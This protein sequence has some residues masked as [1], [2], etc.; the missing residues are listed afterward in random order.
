MRLCPLNLFQ[1]PRRNLGARKLVLYATK[2]AQ[3][4]VCLAGG[5]QPRRSF[6]VRSISRWASRL[7]RLSRLS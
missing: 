7:A 5:R 1:S 3:K 4:T 6:S 2:T